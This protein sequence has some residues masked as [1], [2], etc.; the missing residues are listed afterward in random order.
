[1]QMISAEKHDLLGVFSS[2]CVNIVF[3]GKAALVKYSLQA[4]AAWLEA[5]TIRGAIQKTP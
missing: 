4:Y 3:G 5:L 1:M 2:C